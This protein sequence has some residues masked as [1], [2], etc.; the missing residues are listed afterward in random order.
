M[1]DDFLKP[2]NENCTKKLIENYQA[3]HT[4]TIALQEVPIEKTS[5]YGI[6][7]A[8]SLDDH[9]YKINGAVEKPKQNPPSNLAIIGRYVLSP[10]IFHYLEQTQFDASGEIQLTTALE[11]IIKHNAMHG[12]AYQG[13]RFD[14]G[15]KSGF[16]AAT[17]DQANEDPELKKHCN[18]QVKAPMT[19]SA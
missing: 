3:H 8:D 14:C 2:Q 6:V 16:I 5:S 13:T 18:Q 7:K 1:A 19:E 9:Y 12:Y 10:T 17:L 11:Q 15:S 4:S